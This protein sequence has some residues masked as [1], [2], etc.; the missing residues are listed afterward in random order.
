MKVKIIQVFYF[1]IFS[2]A[3]FATTQ[4]SILLKKV[5]VQLKIQ[6]SEIN[7]ELATD[8]VLPYA[9]DKTVLVIPKYIKIED[10]GYGNISFDLDAYIVIANT[11]TGEILYE[12]YEPDAW[13]SDALRISSI[14]I[15][16]RLYI[17]NNTNR[18]FGVRVNYSGSSQVNPYNS[19]DFSLY[20]IEKNIL[21]IV[22]ENFRISEYHGEW[23]TR[24]TGKF[25]DINSVISIDKVQS[26][27][28]N[29]LIIK[30]ITLET[31]STPT[32]INDDCI[33]KIKTKVKFKK[34]RYDG[35]EYK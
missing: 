16:T 27:D 4:D 20:I 6:E 18:A 25:E 7:L 1:L 33:E 31:I 2:Q 8:K 29:N 14:E 17:L 12:L 23:D 26:N 22:L 15:D 30:S 11:V 9:I 19:T 32:P 13:T 3:L 28:F 5:L 34:L 35:V 24:C 21:K 10:D